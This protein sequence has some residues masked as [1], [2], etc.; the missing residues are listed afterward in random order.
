MSLRYRQLEGFTYGGEQKEVERI[1]KERSAACSIRVN[2][3]K[4]EAW[5]SMHRVPASGAGRPPNQPR[6]SALVQ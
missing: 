5:G 4:W 6:G 2:E 3:R 1:G